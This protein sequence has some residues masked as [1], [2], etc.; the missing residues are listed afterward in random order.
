LRFEF[1]S[2]QRI[3]FGPGVI[4]ELPAIA[5]GFGKRAFVVTGKDRIRRA[6]I[7]AELE[8]AGMTCAIFA[9]PGEP[10]VDLVR[11]GAASLRIA[12]SD[13]VIA[14]GG[15]SVIDAGKAIA[16]LAANP[17]DVL[18]YLEIVG[19]G[20]P[21]LN[22]SIPFIAV[23]TTAGTGSEV[24]R[25]AVLGSPEHR[26]KASLRSAFMLP[27]VALVDPELTVGLPREIAANTGLDALTQLIEP[28][29]SNRA[30]PI[31]DALCL[32]GL[33]QAARCLSALGQP[34]SRA[35]MSYAS[36]L[37]GLAL[38]NA[39]LGVVHGFAAPIGGMFNA[40]HGGVCAAILPH[41]MAA[42]LKALRERA[43]ES[44]A[45]ERYQEIARI[46]TGHPKATPEDALEWVAKLVAALGIPPLSRYGITEADTEAIVDKAARSSSMKANPITLTPEE[47][48]TVLRKAG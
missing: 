40:P 32:D 21:L 28:Y 34:E 4:R 36:L 23:P 7:L 10:T 13:V 31:T 3:V 25:N 39:G 44:P 20:S 33:R 5:L 45:I 29:V 38:A 9:V 26:V 42:N 18:D 30:N 2:A 14:L 19:R 17:G 48:A 1:A 12:A 47:L 46:L 11:A 22:P 15:G 27:R 41:G 6:G 43:P 35:G 16:A 37:G 24:T 8:A